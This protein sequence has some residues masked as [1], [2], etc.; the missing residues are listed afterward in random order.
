MPTTAW[1][2]PYKRRVTYR[3]ALQCY[4]K[5]IQINPEHALAHHNMGVV[6]HQQGKLDEALKHYKEAIRIDPNY[7][8]AHNDMGVT[9]QK[10]GDLQ[11]ALQCYTK[12]IQIN[13]EHALAHRNMGVVLRQQGK[14]DEA[15]KH[16][17]EAIRIDLNDAAAHNNMGVTLLWPTGSIAVLHQGHPGQPGTCWAHQEHGGSFASPRQAR[18]GLE[19]LQRKPSA[20]I[21]TMLMPTAIWVA[22]CDKE[23]ATYRGHCSATPRPSRSTQNMPW[24]IRNM[25]VVLRQQGKLDEA[26]K[27]YKEA[28]RIDP[29]D[30]E[31]PQAWVPP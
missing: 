20:L 22:Y 21:P 2:S 15:L 30:A 18:W 25:G 8:D 1:V 27:H 6:L 12:A 9:L 13:P 26:L 14:L 29:N 3:E 24:H 16:Y 11:G 23:K 17:K 19:I 7:A 28:I 4:T 10:K 31:C 5:A